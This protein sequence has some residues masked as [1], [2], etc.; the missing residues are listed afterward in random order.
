MEK[1]RKEIK[2]DENTLFSH[3][4]TEFCFYSE[5]AGVWNQSH[6]ENEAILMLH[7]WKPQHHMWR[8]K[9]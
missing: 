1:Q 4:L 3:K 7:T 5:A 8:V 6:V 2:T 9:P